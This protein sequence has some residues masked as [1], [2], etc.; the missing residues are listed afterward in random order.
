[1]AQANPSTAKKK[2]KLQIKSAGNYDFQE[3]LVCG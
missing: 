2:K 1:M 3:R